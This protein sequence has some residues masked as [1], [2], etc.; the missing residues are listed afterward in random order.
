MIPAF[1]SEFVRT[2]VIM[3][4][5]GSMLCLLLLAIKPIIRYRLPK[6]A[7]Y[8]FWLVV[9][10]TFILPVSRIMIL[11]GAIVD[12]TPI[13]YVVERTVISTAEARDRFPVMDMSIPVTIPNITNA[14]NLPNVGVPMIILEEMPTLEEPGFVTQA[15]TIF[16]AIYPFV[17]AFVLLY[18][19]T[20]YVCFVRKLRRNN[21]DPPSFDLDMLRELTLG[22]RTPKLIVSDDAATPML[23]GIFRP[24]IV[25]PNREYTHEQ[26]QSILHHELTHMRRLDIAIKWLSLLACAAHWFNPLV[27]ITK[28]E[29]D[30]ACELSCDEIVIRNMDA[31]NKQHYGETLIS[32][33]STQKIP[34]PVLS[35]TMCEEKRA[36]KER[37]TAIMKSKKHTKLA[38]F[39]STI[40]LLTVVL[41]ACTMGAGSSRHNT[42]ANTVVSETD[43]LESSQQM[44]DD[45]ISEMPTTTLILDR[46]DYITISG[47]LYSTDLTELFLGINPDLPNLTDEDILPL[48]YMNNLTSLTLQSSQI[49][50]I[51]PLAGLNNL[52]VL[53]FIDSQ[54]TDFIPLA[55]LE[56]LTHLFLF[57]NPIADITLLSELENITYL[58]LTNNQITDITP[59][60]TF[61]HLRTLIL[62]NNQITDISPLAMLTNLQELSLIDNH[63]TDISPL[64]ELVQL[65]SLILRNNQ[66]T[67][68]SPLAALT[69]LWRISL[70]NNQITDI[71]PLAELAHLRTLHLNNNQ[72]T[73]INPIAALTN[74]GIIYLDGN[75]NIDISSLASLV[76]LREL[77]L[78]NNQITDISPLTA[79]DNLQ[80]IYLSDN[81]ITDINP[82]TGLT[83][84]SVL[85]L[86]NNQITDISPL[87]E[88]SDNQSI[89][90]IKV[91]NL[92]SLAL[93]NNQISNITSLTG[94]TH[95]DYLRLDG[96]QVTDISPLATLTNLRRIILFNNQITDIN[97]LVELTNLTDLILFNN[98]ISD[99]TPLAGLANLNTL[100]VAGNPITDFSAVTHVDHIDVDTMG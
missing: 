84:L 94:L 31:Y 14:Q 82:L 28:R 64:S 86:S 57:N 80:R 74:L 88:L 69:N 48:R 4:I 92:A 62:A 76:H 96:N 10:A 7:Q 72:I 97:P 46:P 91:T 39:I 35:T 83:N 71:T 16:M 66:I 63:V 24:M 12:I 23:I 8:Y 67:D 53:S 85:C 5:T 99:L 19:L 25:L 9:L 17:F 77:S 87:A 100:W 43:E 36:L 98:H 58:L 34:L 6:S 54:I 55:N 52:T 30:R 61:G 42:S 93:S 38:I 21:I 33:A 78:R 68:I 60:A 11:P 73:D 18:G 44:E 40:I 56:N 22:K 45:L 75:H 41:V 59:L 81:Y 20:G 89:S 70:E 90:P 27:W 65:R 29:I 95:L 32:V 49:T 37:L 47:R 79:L 51:S 15:I 26:M 3:T 50:D 1:L 13:H 2:V